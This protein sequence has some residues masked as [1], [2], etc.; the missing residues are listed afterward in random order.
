MATDCLKNAVF[1][2]CVFVLA[3]VV[4]KASRFIV[5]FFQDTCS[6]LYSLIAEKKRT[7]QNQTCYAIP[8]IDFINSRCHFFRRVIDSELFFT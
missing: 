8:S 6:Q 4:M 2:S 3:R 1:T 7:T 5:S